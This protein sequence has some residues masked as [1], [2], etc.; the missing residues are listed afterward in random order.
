MFAIAWPAALVV[1]FCVMV[2]SV[3]ISGLLLLQG[4]G[5]M[6]GGRMVGLL[7]AA[8]AAIAVLA[9]MRRIGW[10]QWPQRAF[11]LIGIPIPAVLAWVGLF[12]MQ[13][14][15][16]VPEEVL[17]SATLLSAVFSIIML[18]IGGRRKG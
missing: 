9:F 2:L 11:W 13:R 4:G 17:A 3:R 6:T 1:G 7:N 8:V 10:G 15:M 5:A 16:L 18:T 12:A 14:E